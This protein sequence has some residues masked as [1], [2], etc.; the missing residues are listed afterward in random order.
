MSRKLKVAQVVDTL[1]AG[2]SERTAVDLANGLIEAGLEVFF[3]VT[4]TDGVLR[5]E[6]DSNIVFVNLE[7]KRRF[8]GLSK[9]RRFVLA[10]DIDVVHAHGNSSAMFCVAALIG[11]KR[12]RIVHHDHNSQ[13]QNR[14]KFLQRTIL[15]RVHTWIAVSDSIRTWVEMNVRPRSLIMINNPIRLSRFN[16]PREVGDHVKRVV[17][18]ANY[19]SPKGYE[20]LISAVDELRRRNLAFSVHCFGRKT[21]D[22]YFESIQHQITEFG[23]GDRVFLHPPSTDIPQLL[24]R[25]DIGVMASVREGLPISLLEYMASRL[26][27]VVT[28]VGECGRVVS[29]ANCGIVVEPA[30]PHALADGIE[31]LLQ[32]VE[33]QHQYGI[34]GR[35]YV[36]KHHSL[37][38]FTGSILELYSRP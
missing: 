27:V 23:L 2:G 33:R 5:S 14:N 24:S 9:F 10:N 15:G 4:R 26:P 25:M 34:K 37:E 36:E 29:Q 22:V 16:L 1:N 18:V 31:E 30:N 8:D 38:S 20:Y 17:V 3:C 32:D 28:N 35:Q 11:M 21:D 13:L 6:L 7:R 19:R 12:V